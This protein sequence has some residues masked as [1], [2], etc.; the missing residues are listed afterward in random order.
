MLSHLLILAIGLIAGGFGQYYL[1]DRRRI[2]TAKDEGWLD[3]YFEQI[4]IERLKRERNGRFRRVPAEEAT[5][6][7]KPVE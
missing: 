6:A 3:R 5:A 1:V 7:R 2:E 4:R